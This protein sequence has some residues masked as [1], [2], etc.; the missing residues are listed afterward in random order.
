MNGKLALAFLGHGWE[1]EA[2]SLPNENRAVASKQKDNSFWNPLRG[3]IHA[4]PSRYV[5]G[6]P[7]I[8]DKIGGTL[9]TG[10]L[11]P[12]IAWARYALSESLNLSGGKPFNVILSRSWPIGAHLPALIASRKMGIPWIA[13]WNDPD[14][15]VRNPVP[16]GEGPSAPISYWLSNY[17]RSVATSASCHTFP[18]TRMMDYMT[19]MYPEMKGK[20]FVIPHVALSG[21]NTQTRNGNGRFVLCH[22][23]YLGTRRD[24]SNLFQA[25]SIF[26]SKT[27][28]DATIKLVLMG[29]DYDLQE[30]FRFSIPSG[31]SDIVELYP[32]SDYTRSTDFMKK[33][34]VLIIIEAALQDGIYLPSKLT[35]YVE[36]GR[37]ILAISPKNGVIS[38][39]VKKYGGG[40]AAD[41]TSPEEIAFALFKMYESWG[42]GGL[43]KEYDLSALSTIFS[44]EAVLSE[45]L[46]VFK[47]IG[48]SSGRG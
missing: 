16:Y 44:E 43:E 3:I 32:W 48:V 8:L 41:C 31:V 22:A 2:I 28:V 47:A 29:N 1:V 27:K 5:K 10:H 24:P 46:R 23:G 45:Y 37:P 38:D 40:I 35:D 39:L 30:K 11:V 20:A 25:L 21:A 42:K 13:N 26:L 14:P 17:M 6:I 15:P 18:S 12:G 19:G 4:V 34:D 7:L 9:L 33:A 36:C